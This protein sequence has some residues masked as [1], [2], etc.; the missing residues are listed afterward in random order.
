MCGCNCKDKGLYTSSDYR[1]D[2]HTHDKPLEPVIYLDS[3]PDNSYPVRILEAYL[4]NTRVR[5]EATNKE[6]E[7]ILNSAQEERAK[8]LEKAIDILTQ[9]I[10]K[11]RDDK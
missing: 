4:Y 6:L 1:T 2:K 9:H 10:T 3:T 8:L 11:D 5:T 7:K